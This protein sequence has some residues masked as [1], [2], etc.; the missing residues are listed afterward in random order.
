MK[1]NR[2]I[3]SAPVSDRVSPNHEVHQVPHPVFL[4]PK[5]LASRWACS[6][7]KLK[8]MRRA[9]KLPVYYIGRAARHKLADVL[10][11]ETEA[12]AR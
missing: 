8:R 10:R 11:I 4:T 9:G 1:Q 5:Q 12:A 2:S 6:I 7:E 3:Q